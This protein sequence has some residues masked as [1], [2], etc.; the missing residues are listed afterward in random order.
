MPVKLKSFKDD[1]SV[2]HSW[3]GE[4]L[5]Y[6]SIAKL[7]IGDR[8][9]VCF[10]DCENELHWENIYVDILKIDKYRDGGKVKKFVCKTVEVY[11]E[12]FQFCKEGQIVNVQPHNILEIPAWSI[13]PDS[14]S[15]SKRDRVVKYLDASYKREIKMMDV[16]YLKIEEQRRQYHDV[17][18]KIAA[19]RGVGKNK[20][21]Q[22]LREHFNHHFLGEFYGKRGFTDK[23]IDKTVC[24]LFGIA[25]SS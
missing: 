19:K 8:I 20:I 7:Q 12:T 16:E 2:P 23:Y 22:K 4:P 18:K 6:D 24:R 13:F 15:D 5:G 1:K 25:Y 11:S 14:D 3:G 21:A 9:R 17:L 10:V